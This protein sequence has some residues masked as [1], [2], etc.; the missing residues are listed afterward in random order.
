MYIF[1]LKQ[2]LPLTLSV[3]NLLYNSDYKV[4]YEIL[5]Y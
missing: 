2:K 4:W 1:V 3:A 5:G